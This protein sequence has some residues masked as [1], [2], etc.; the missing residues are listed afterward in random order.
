MPAHHGQ[1]RKLN[2]ASIQ[3]KT[4]LCRFYTTEE[5]CA[6]G[7][8]CAFAHGAEEFRASPLAKDV[9]S[10]CS[11]D[12]TTSVC[13]EE[14]SAESVCS[15]VQSTSTASSCGALSSRQCWADVDDDNDDEWRSI[16]APPQPKVHERLT[17]SNLPLS[18]QPELDKRTLKTKRSEQAAEA[19]RAKRAML[20]GAVLEGLLRQ[21][22]MPY[23]YED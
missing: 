10:N 5:G 22:Q 1:A 20:T 14:M 7:A 4:R 8:S 11:S 17:A 2:R 6:N 21:A 23:V 16:W 9:A 15:S 3:H 13:S 12:D 19:A 18:E